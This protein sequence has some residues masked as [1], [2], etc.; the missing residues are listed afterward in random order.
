MDLIAPTEFAF[1]EAMLAELLQHCNDMEEGQLLQL[2]A[3]LQAIYAAQSKLHASRNR[4]MAL[5]SQTRR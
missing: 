1:M 2:H 3:R 5:Q 4:L